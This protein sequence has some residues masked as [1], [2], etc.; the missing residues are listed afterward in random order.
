MPILHSVRGTHQ[1]VEADN[2]TTATVPYR[3]PA[4]RFRSIPYEVLVMNQSITSGVAMARHAAMLRVHAL[5]LREVH[6]TGLS[7]GRLLLHL[8]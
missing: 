8:H 6:M 4:G 3:D 2:Q 1:R 7:D 5:A